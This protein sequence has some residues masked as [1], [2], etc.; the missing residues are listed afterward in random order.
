MGC[1]TGLLLKFLNKK[2]SKYDLTGIDIISNKKTKNIKFIK[3]EFFKYIPKSKFSY[4]ISIAVIEH[5]P[6]VKKYLDYL[7][8]ISNKDA[9]FIILTINT[10]S[11]LYK[12]AEILYF[13][14]FKKPFVR[15]FD[16]HHLNHFSNKSL[17]KFL[18]KNGYYLVERINTPISMKQI[19]YP[20]EN[21]F[22]KYILYVGLACML[23]AE[24]I[25]NK[26]WL[27]TVIFKKK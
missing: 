9:Y 20:Y 7:R 19:D 3:K 27:Q 1:G 8:K 5:V 11:F 14:G 23:Q 10:N 25:F 6:K 17:N 13:F 24:K 12:I 21:I 15:L 4:I 26:S 22:T 18:D 2:N 16:P